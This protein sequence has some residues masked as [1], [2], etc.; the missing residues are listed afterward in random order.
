LVSTDFKK[1]ELRDEFFT[2]GGGM[3]VRKVRTG[4][5]RS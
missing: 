5:G 3:F 4:A 1:I 2:R